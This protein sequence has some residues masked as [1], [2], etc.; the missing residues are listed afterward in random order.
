[1][2]GERPLDEFQDEEMYPLLDGQAEHEISKLFPILKSVSS[3]WQQ[4]IGVIKMNE[5]LSL[6]AWT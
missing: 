6:S 4:L 1:M 5:T 2:Y 3:S